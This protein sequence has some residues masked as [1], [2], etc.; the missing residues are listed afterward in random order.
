MQTCC[1]C[2]SIA[3]VASRDFWNQ[4]LHETSNFSV[5]PSLGSLIEGWVLIVPKRHVICMGELPDQLWD[6][7]TD[8]K[9]TI[10]AALIERYGEVCAF[11]HGPHG[12]NREVGCG[13]DHAH[14]H[15]VPISTKIDLAKAAESFLPAG[16]AWSAATMNDCRAAF[17]QRKDYLYVEQQAAGRIATGTALGGQ[18]FRKAIAAQLG[19]P[20]EFNWRE[21]PRLGIVRETVEKLHGSMAVLA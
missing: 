7:M 4:P 9:T 12:P 1:I 20:G 6:E 18:I 13:V 15:L 14:L 8:L 19:I 5:V 11:E 10:A 17:S 2:T 3:S 21:Y 16:T